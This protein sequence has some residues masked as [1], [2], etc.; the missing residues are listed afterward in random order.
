MLNP[1]YAIIEG[2]NTQLLVS[3]LVANINGSYRVIDNNQITF[4]ASS[5]QNLLTLETLNQSWTYGAWLIRGNS[6]ELIGRFKTASEAPD[7]TFSYN[8]NDGTSTVIIT[9][10]PSG[11]QSSQP[12][13]LLKLL[14]AAIPSGVGS[15]IRSMTYNSTGLPRGSGII[16]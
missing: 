13:T 1:G 14:Y 16:N 2:G 15:E 7:K 4:K 9:V 6:A 12:F 8:I 10:E 5:G 11:T 3:T